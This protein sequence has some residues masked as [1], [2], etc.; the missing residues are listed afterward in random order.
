MFAENLKDLHFRLRNM[1]PKF[2]IYNEALLE[3]ASCGDD[4][5]IEPLVKAGADVN[6]RDKE[7]NTSLMNAARYG[8]KECVKELIK[9]AAVIN[10]CN[11][12]GQ[13]ALT[14]AAKFGH[15]KCIDSLV[16]AGADVNETDPC[17]TTPLIY[18]AKYGY[19]KCVGKLLKIDCNCDDRPLLWLD[20][21]KKRA[22]I[23]IKPTAA[24][25]NL[26]LMIAAYKGHL[27]CV[28]LLITA[29]ANVNM[30]RNN[31]NNALA[32]ATLTNNVEC[33]KLL[34]KSGSFVNNANRNGP[35]ALQDRIVKGYSLTLSNETYVLLYV[36][37][38]KFD[39]SEEPDYSL[40]LKHLCRKAIRTHLI[41]V[42]SRLNLFC[43]VP[44]LGLP[45]RL[46][47][48]LLFNVHL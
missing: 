37:G 38:Q 30:V 42:G 2:W 36:A 35:N 13:N 26:A 16:T 39:S 8:Q 24:N 15:F 11:R 47:S 12:Y 25:V 28:E 5:L 20:V 9:M 7:D 32:Y 43:K 14:K 4:V 29:G 3:A 6:A 10:M 40:D 1:L 31:G 44:L 33:V 21:E 46:V 18:A 45:P 41:N 27:K 34:L 23:R 17:G 48:Y 19:N 22:V